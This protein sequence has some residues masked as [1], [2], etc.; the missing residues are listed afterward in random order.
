MK[1]ASAQLRYLHMTPR[2]VRAVAGLIRGR[3]VN[4][5]EAELLLHR[6]RAA[7]PLLKLLRSAVANAKQKKM[8]NTRLIVKEIRVDQGP[9]LKRHL[10]RARGMASPI[11]KKMSNIMMV[12]VEDERAKT[13]KF[14]FIPAPKKKKAPVASRTKK[15]QDKQ[16]EG[17][18]D[19]MPMQKGSRRQ[20]GFWKKMFQRKSV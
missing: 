6:R 12:L 2:K 16:K 18:I 1:N 4:D 3:M 8:D 20:N 10:P 13:P 9:M 7:V 5:A 15:T 14:T 19:E 11:Q 17:G